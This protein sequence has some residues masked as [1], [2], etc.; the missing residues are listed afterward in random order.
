MRTTKKTDT[1]DRDHTTTLVH[2]RVFAIYKESWLSRLY[3]IEDML[4]RT[5]TVT[6]LFNESS[7]FGSVILGTS[8]ILTWH[9]PLWTARNFQSFSGSAK[10]IIP[11]FSLGFIHSRFSRACQESNTFLLFSNLLGLDPTPREALFAKLDE[12]SEIRGTIGDQCNP[13]TSLW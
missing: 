4:H 1:R 6:S 7:K 13:A 10:G 8:N 2:V 12:P 9:D 5:S 11:W 3:S